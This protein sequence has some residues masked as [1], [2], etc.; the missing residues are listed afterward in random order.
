[1]YQLVAGIVLACAIASASFWAGSTGKFDAGYL[2]GSTDGFKRGVA[3]T[4]EL[5]DKELRAYI[6]EAREAAEKARADGFQKA[7]EQERARQDE[8]QQAAR[9]L[10]R[11]KRALA[12]RV[13]SLLGRVRDYETARSAASGDGGVPEAGAADLARAETAR[14]LS[15]V[16]REFLRTAGAADAESADFA[17][18][19]REFYGDRVADAVSGP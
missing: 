2:E 8:I 18:C 16:S 14:L 17:A 13:A 15:E 6:A 19:Y 7:L 10:E 4:N 5:R 12:S 11:D 3:R 1:M 9:R